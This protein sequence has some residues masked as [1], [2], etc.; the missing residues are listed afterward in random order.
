MKI[1]RKIGKR[2]TSVIMSIALLVPV[3][4]VGFGVLNVTALEKT[5]NDAV[6]SDKCFFAPE[7]VY[8][9]PSIASYTSQG[10]Y[11]F[12]WFVD[13]EINKSAHTATPRTGE[14]S[15]GNF[16]FYY[17]YANS[18]SVSFKYLNT[19][20]NDITAY[21]DTSTT[22]SGA[23]YSN[24][25]CYIKFAASD[26]ISP[27]NTSS[28]TAKT[29]YTVSGNTV[30][31]T[32]TNSSVSPYMLANVSGC[33]IEWTVS[34]VDSRTGLTNYVKSY[35][36]LYKPYIQPLGI[37]IRIQ[38]NRGTDSYGS[39][40]A[41]ISGVHGLATTGSHY[42]HAQTGSGGM[43]PFSSSN[44]L[45]VQLGDV[46]DK[47]YAQFANSTQENGY[48][49]Y[50][51]NNTNPDN[52][53]GTSGNTYFTT[54]SFNYVNNDRDG[55][56]SGDNA[57]YAYGIS[58]IGKMSIDSSRYTNLSQIPNLSIG[59]MVTDDEG[60][61]D[62]GAWY[63]ADYTGK[64]VKTAGDTGY[65]KNSTTTGENYWNDRNDILFGVGSF[66][67][68][69]GG[70]S[71]EGV[72]YN[73]KW[74]YN[75]ATSNSTATY[76]FK[77]GYFNHDGSGSHYGGDTCWDFSVLQLTATLSDRTSLRSAYNSAASKSA[78]LGMK[79]DGSSYFYDSSSSY[80]T[81]FMN[82]YKAAG[83]LLTNIDSISSVTVNGTSYTY[84]LLASAL[85]SAISSIENCRLSSTSTERHLVITK[86]SDGTY[87]LSTLSPDSTLSYQY[88]NELLFSSKTIENYVY[89]GYA[90]NA[91]RSSGENVGNSYASLIASNEKTER[92]Y[93]TSANVS[94]TF[95]YVPRQVVSIAV[96]TAPTKQYYRLG[97]S[98]DYSGLVIT[99]TFNDNTTE[100]LTGYTCSGFDS[101]TPNVCT[102]TVKYNDCTTMFTVTVLGDA[103]Y[104]NVTAAKN[105]IPGDLSVYTSETVQNLNNAVNAVVYGLDITHQSEV[106]AYANAINSA[107]NALVYKKADYT[108]VTNALNAVPNDL[109]NYTSETVNALNS[110]INSV[111]YNLDI[112][113]QSQVDAYA[114]A[115]VDATAAL[116]YKRR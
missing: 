61:K 108:A 82:L 64:T 49:Q 66:N 10:K 17:Q 4:S 109:S 12:Q 111:V 106:D 105:R 34:F 31:T 22:N 102:I 15:S 5:G 16:Y 25:D 41:W 107:I 72:K 63:I 26:N 39:D 3:F 74:L 92:T 33:Y 36:Y 18:I 40:V 59:L 98:A 80:W 37:G 53:F 76:A 2:I 77:T 65:Q 46:G 29:S 58:P 9:Q 83:K 67:S 113:Y 85:N 84:D 55:S 42:P 78:N 79:A 69:V 38:N 71:N 30:D 95:F 43:V 88:G 21:T 97:N 99:G 20:F 101:S 6:V 73:G 13:S 114:K 110:A 62:S 93:P 116:K 23:N 1:R 19:D 86:G 27:S 90:A 44:A 68:T 47:L 32:V 75:I 103:D 57:F 45:G 81:N 104:S 115:I 11:N 87:S 112:I 94:C 50:S 14:N 70:A 60:T 48:F 8:L 52:W 91:N 54:Q 35:T 89:V 28:D 56:S 100:A 96:T 24:A 51:C 7:A